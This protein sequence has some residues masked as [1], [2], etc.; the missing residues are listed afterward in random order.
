MLGVAIPADELSANDGMVV[1]S[2]GSM[3][4]LSLPNRDEIVRV[5]IEE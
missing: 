2:D 5:M 1:S 4:L 3:I